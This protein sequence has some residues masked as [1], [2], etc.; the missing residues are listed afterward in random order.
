MNKK[1]KALSLYAI[2]L[3]A[4]ILV[5]LAPGTAQDPLVSLSRL[6]QEITDLRN[7]FNARINAISTSSGSLSPADIMFLQETIREALREELRAELREELLQEVQGTQFTILELRANETIV[8]GEGT[9]II[10]RSGTAT[11]HSQVAN[12]LAD[13]TT[14]IELF[15]GNNVPANH[16]LL[17]SRND[18]RGITATSDAWVIVEG[19]FT[20]TRG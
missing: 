17:V 20:I 16:L 7:Y 15:N 2:L 3:T 11:I 18:G 19:S 13:L 8:G 12:G 5:G 6:N 14:G 4:V 9:R 10:L 1:F